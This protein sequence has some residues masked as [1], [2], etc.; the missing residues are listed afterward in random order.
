MAEHG[1]ARS[2]V[3]AYVYLDLVRDGGSRGAV[4]TR[5]E[6]GLRVR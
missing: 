4:V 1:L 3:E 5:E 2:L 6:D